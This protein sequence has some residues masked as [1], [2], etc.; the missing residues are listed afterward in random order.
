MKKEMVIGYTTGVFDMFHIGHLNLLRRAK[1]HCDY[2][3]VGVHRDASHKGKDAFIPFNERCEI[4]RSTKYVDKVIESKREDSDVYE[5]I[6][7]R[8]LFVGSDYKGTERFERYEKY[9]EN[10][11]VE[12]VYLPYTQTTNSTKLREALD[13]NIMSKQND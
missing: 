2:L 4:L 1:E 10:K 11:G 5:D 3:V 13:S 8:F 7:Y 9:F 12:I 6:K